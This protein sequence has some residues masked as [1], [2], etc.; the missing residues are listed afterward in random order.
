MESLVRDAVSSDREFVIAAM[1][2]VLAPY[3]DGDH[4]A[5]ALRIFQTHIEGGRDK[6][7]HFSAEQ[8]MFVAE[9]DG[10]R[11]GL[12]HIVGKRQGTYKISPLIVAPEY[13]GTRGLGTTL[14]H[15]AEHYAKSHDARQMYCTVAVQN[16]GAHQFFLKRGYVPA[17][18]SESHYKAGVTEAML[19]KLFMN[20]AFKQELERPNISVTE[21]QPHQENGCRTLI[22]AS[23]SEHFG[24]V[25]E[26]WVEALFSGYGRRESKDVNQKYKLIYVAT[27][28]TGAVIGVACAT[29]KK[30]EPVKLMPFIAA[31]YQAFVAMLTDIPFM[32]R[33]Y[34]HKLYMHISPSVEETIALQRQGWSLDAAMPGAYRDD[35]ITQQ[36]GFTLGERLM[37]K[38]RVKQGFFDQIRS[39][40]KTLEVRVGYDSIRTI[41]PGE[42]IELMTSTDQQVIKVNAVRRYFTF[43]EMLNGENPSAIVP[44]S[45][46][47]EV[48]SLLQ[49]IYP[50][51]K[52][53]LGVVVLEVHPVV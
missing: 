49:R 9:V 53:R 33:V 14:L 52:E 4:T 45:S 21:M 3:Y 37:R 2:Q 15:R 44:G 34:G 35:V 24:G 19:Y 51:D 5:H 22:E 32:L 13:R 20:E 1:N 42:K 11:A 10:C 7:G 36:W 17:G 23:V 46:R 18:R 43:D 38:M 50:S 26:G 12:V 31:N 41:Q 47:S 29:P 6:V 16:H 8:H 39:G 28:R 25:D 40:K 48:L 30:G 27:D